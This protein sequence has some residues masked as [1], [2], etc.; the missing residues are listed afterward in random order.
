LIKEVANLHD[1]M[2]VE[3]F[4]T[5]VSFL[6]ISLPILKMN[7]NELADVFESSRSVPLRE[8]IPFVEQGGGSGVSTRTRPKKQLALRESDDDEDEH[9]EEQ[10]SEEERYK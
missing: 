3:V 10:T 2:Q 6:A 1:G 4:C 5:I 9:D 8:P 7:S